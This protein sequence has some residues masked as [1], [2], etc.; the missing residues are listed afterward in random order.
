MKVVFL[1]LLASFAVFSIGIKDKALVADNAADT[2]VSFDTSKF[3]GWKEST[4]KN[5]SPGCK[6]MDWTKAG[7]PPSESTYTK[8]PVRAHYGPYGV[9]GSTKGFFMHND[10]T[11]LRY[12]AKLV[13]SNYKAE[14]KVA[15]DNNVQI[16]LNG[17]ELG[18]STAF[19]ATE[20]RK[21]FL[22]WNV[23]GN[24]VVSG[25]NGA[26]TVGSS[27]VNFKAGVN[28]FV[29][30]V[31]NCGGGDKGSIE[32][33]VKLTPTGCVGTHLERSECH[34]KKAAK[35][36]KKSGHHKSQL[37]KHAGDA[38]SHTKN[39]AQ[40]IEYKKKSLKLAKDAKAKAKKHSDQ[41]AR[42]TTKA[43]TAFKEFEKQK[44]LAKA[45]LDKGESL[46]K[47][48]DKFNTKAGEHSKLALEFEN[49]A[50]KAWTSFMDHLKQA[51]LHEQKR[52]HHSEK[53]LHHLGKHYMGY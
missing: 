17:V 34:T 13:S 18:H 37:G 25:L 42:H 2:P 35:H 7:K 15:V 26:K 5:R 46:S 39:K 48:S 47:K 3:A 1:L 20:W 12:K 24:G 10:I 31:R 44:G 28:E 52:A 45:E 22:Q 4:Y 23:N 21:P 11:Y 19:S 27:K 50:K 29:F 6:H 16:F 14:I 40:S 43:E 36:A 32:T 51:K 33:S 8:N 30:A 53:E 9:T 49:K 38:K 41:S